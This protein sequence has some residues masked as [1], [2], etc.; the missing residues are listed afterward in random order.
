MPAGPA[1]RGRRSSRRPATRSGP[2]PTAS[3]VRTP[4][5]APAAGRSAGGAWQRSRPSF[6]A[7]R[8]GQPRLDRRGDKQLRTLIQVF[9]LVVVELVRGNHLAHYG[10]LRFVVAQ[11]ADLEL[12]RVNRALDHQL[13]IERGGEPETRGQL[14]AIVCFGRANTRA[15]VRELGEAWIADPL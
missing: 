9:G 6:V 1:R 5:A 15:G 7:P 13:P 12:A 3:R 14:G 2:W 11:D 4:P 8:V 10:G